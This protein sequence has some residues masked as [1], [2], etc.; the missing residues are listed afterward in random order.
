MTGPKPPNKRNKQVADDEDEDAQLKEEAYGKQ[1]AALRKG[2][3]AAQSKP[4]GSDSTAVQ[5][6]GARV[7]GFLKRTQ[8]R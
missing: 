4:A 1:G 2:L 5:K 8:G 7:R 6:L 3:A